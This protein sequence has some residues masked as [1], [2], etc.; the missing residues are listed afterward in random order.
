[1]TSLLAQIREA[2]PSGAA[3]HEVE[4]YLSSQGC[5]RRQIGEIMSLLFPDTSAGGSHGGMNLPAS[6]RVLG[7]H[8][9]GRFAPEAWG[10]LVTLRGAGILN[11][12]ELEYVI[13]R[14]LL[15]IDGR[16][17]LDD[18]RAMMDGAGFEDGGGAGEHTT[19][20]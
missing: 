6:V 9:Q 18:L 8:E 4:A 20:H 12:A 15:H 10:H 14:A 2:F 5:D 11:A 19:V 16:I 3:P 17:A 13:E 7:P 1:M